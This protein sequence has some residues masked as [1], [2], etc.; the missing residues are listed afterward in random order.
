MV[1][2]RTLECVTEAWTRTLL[3]GSENHEFAAQH[4]F[5]FDG[6]AQSLFVR[7]LVYLLFGLFCCCLFFV[8]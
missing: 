1:L 2:L 8:E 3:F 6:D 4:A 7:A 5:V